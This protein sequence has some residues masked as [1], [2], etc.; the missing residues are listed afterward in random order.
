M[1]TTKVGHERLISDLENVTFSTR[2]ADTYFLI[3]MLPVI[4]VSIIL[5][6]VVACMDT[7]SCCSCLCCCDC[8]LPMTERTSNTFGLQEE[9]HTEIDLVEINPPASQNNETTSQQTIS[10]EIQEEA[11]ESTQV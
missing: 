6:S 3:L 11:T 7:C 10:I 9:A 1:T 2:K 8:L 4:V 5:M